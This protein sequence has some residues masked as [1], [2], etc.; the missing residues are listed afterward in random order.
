MDQ[1]GNGSRTGPTITR[2]PER[3]RL[4]V[5]LCYP[6]VFYNSS[7]YNSMTF[8]RFATL[9]C[10]ACGVRILLDETFKNRQCV[11]VYVSVPSSG[12]ILAVT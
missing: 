7:S 1:D 8:P 11:C 10:Y 4:C 2:H 6:T 5:S 9:E 3:I 12:S